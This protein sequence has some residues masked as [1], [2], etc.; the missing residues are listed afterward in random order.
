MALLYILE[1]LCFIK[2]LKGYL[3]H[4]CLF[5][6][7]NKRFNIHL[8]TVSCNTALFQKNVVN[9]SV[10]LYSR[11]P[12]RIKIFSDFKSFKNM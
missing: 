11:L 10:K 3:K 9:M 5:H 7:Y 1:L 4:N 6:R 2:K 12:E 8:H